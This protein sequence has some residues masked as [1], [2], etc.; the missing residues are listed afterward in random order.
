MITN[1]EDMC[2][3]YAEIL[4]SQKS[5]GKAWFKSDSKGNLTEDSGKRQY[6]NI[7]NLPNGSGYAFLREGFEN[8]I[9]YIKTLAPNIILLGH[10]KDIALEKEGGT[11][12]STEL[13]LTGKLKRIATSK[14]DAVG[15]LYRGKQGN[16][17]SFKTKDEIACGARPEHLSNQ[18][19]L[20]SEK[21]D[22]K[23]VT[24][25]DKIYIDKI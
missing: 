6:G 12:N 1:V 13:D 8:I 10:I 23:L 5:M 9:N 7:L 22:G 14:S 4:Y 25:W 3:P 16:I 15:Y 19:I 18:E 24:H 11:V 2:I 21:V 17:L 20:I